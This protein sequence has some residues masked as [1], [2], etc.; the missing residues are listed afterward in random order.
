MQWFWRVMIAVVVGFISG[1]L[2]VYWVNNSALSASI[3]QNLPMGRFW[4]TIATTVVTSMFSA[5]PVLIVAFGA[6]GLLTRYLAPK[7]DF[8]ETRCRKCGYILKGIKEPICSEC[9]E[10]I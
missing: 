9:G 3:Y 10:K 6:Y 2:M 4:G 8:N 7:P 5:I 1:N